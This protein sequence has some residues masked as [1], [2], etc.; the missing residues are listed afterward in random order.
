MLA[1][2]VLAVNLLGAGDFVMRNLTQRYLGSLP[3]GYAASKTGFRVYAALVV[4]IGFLF[5]GFG[6]AETAVSAGVVL[7]AIG[8]LGFVV[9]SVLAI[10]GE[11]T[12]ATRKP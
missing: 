12:T 10:R 6:V 3:P 8:V 11:I 4:A 9:L 1:G 7:F 2:V 5:A